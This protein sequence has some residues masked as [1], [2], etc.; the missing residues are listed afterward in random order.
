M[1]RPISKVAPGWWDYTTLDE[2]ILKDAAKLSA[3]DLLELSRDGFKVRIYDTL[4][5]FYCSEAL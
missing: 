1:P 2:S 5:E 3:D 4:Q